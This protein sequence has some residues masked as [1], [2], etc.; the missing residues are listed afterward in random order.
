MRPKAVSRLVRAIN[1]AFR[2]D[3]RELPRESVRPTPRAAGDLDE[4]EL[5]LDSRAAEGCHSPNLSILSICRPTGPR[6]LAI[7]RMRRAGTTTLGLVA[8]GA[9]AGSLSFGWSATGYRRRSVSVS[10]PTLL[11]VDAF[12][13]C[14]FVVVG[15]RRSLRSRI[16]QYVIPA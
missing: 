11:P 5:I 8:L 15:G 9:G 12:S 4:A 7:L 2:A 6:V 1:P 14:W 16:N 13:A 10:Q 3:R